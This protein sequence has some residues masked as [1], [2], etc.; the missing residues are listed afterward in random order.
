MREELSPHNVRLSF[1]AP[2]MT[3]TPIFDS[4]GSFYKLFNS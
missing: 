4:I 3:E 2:G 1:I